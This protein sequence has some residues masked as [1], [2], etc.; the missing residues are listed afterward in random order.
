MRWEAKGHWSDVGL[1]LSVTSSSE[2][3]SDL[4]LSLTR[5]ET[6]AGAGEIE[7]KGEWGWDERGRG[8]LGRERNIPIKSHD[9]QLGFLSLL[10]QCYPFTVALTFIQ[11][12]KSAISD[13]HN[14]AHIFFAKLF[15]LFLS[16]FAEI[17]VGWNITNFSCGLEASN[18]EVST[19]TA[20]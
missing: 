9:K 1:P 12:L 8:G 18:W 7:S 5:T 2:L 19:G 11:K 17:S 20:W 13:K 4:A 14:A 10:P 16:V 15:I 6:L 3:S